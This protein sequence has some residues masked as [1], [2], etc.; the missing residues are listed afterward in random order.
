MLFRD[1]AEAGRLLGQTLVAQPRTARLGDPVVLGLPRG[2]VPVAYEVAAALSAP[3]DV[4][5]VRKLG[6]PHH[7]ELAMGAVGEH[8]IRVLDRS[9]IAAE[10]IT[11]EQVRSVEVRERDRLTTQ[12]AVFRAGRAA[13]PLAGRSLVLVDDGV[14]T[15]S[16]M[17]AAC[18]V[19]RAHE[20]ALVVVA[21]PVAP[22]AALDPLREAAD[23]V[24]CL[25]TP[26]PFMAVGLWYH[27]FSQVGDDTVVDLL[28]RTTLPG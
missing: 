26:R 25:H 4:I 17:L 8:G 10:H 23:D 16:T 27:D 13:V 18:R 14:A 15:G 24:V 9:V 5:V 19:A 22:R 2:G 28:R 7:R 11:D 6:V 20:A 21:V 3:M 1:R 12:A